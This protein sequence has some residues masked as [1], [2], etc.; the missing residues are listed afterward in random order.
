MRDGGYRRNCPTCGADH[1]PRTDPVVIMSVICG[2]EL[3]LGRQSS[4]PQGMYSTLA[5]FMEPGEAIEEAV[6]R[7][8]F[9]ESGVKVKA[10]HYLTSQPWPFPSSLM[11]GALA[12]TDDP[13]LT[14]DTSELETA[15][16]F[17]ADELRQMLDGTHP[18]G[19]SAPRPYAIARHLIEAALQTLDGR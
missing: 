17:A 2:Q 1:F 8:V 12:E 9:E 5:G 14:I 15:R 6:A 13:K 4:W 10:V 11:I 3:L 16:W 18:R 7:E 19:L